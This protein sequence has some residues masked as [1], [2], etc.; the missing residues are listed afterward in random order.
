VAYR[1]ASALN[2]GQKYVGVD[3]AAQLYASGGTFLYGDLVT[4][5]FSHVGSGCYLFD[6]NYPNGFYGHVA[7][8]QSGSSGVLGLVDISPRLEQIL[9]IKGKTDLL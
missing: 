7:I 5:G 6:Y 8:Y 4:S 3:L 2:L 9:Y 1:I